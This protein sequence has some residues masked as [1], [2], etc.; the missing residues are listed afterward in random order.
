MGRWRNESPPRNFRGRALDPR[1]SILGRIGE[2]AGRTG[3]EL[4]PGGQRDRISDE[5]NRPVPPGDVDATRVVAAGGEVGFLE[6]II[7][8]RVRV[9]WVGLVRDT[10]VA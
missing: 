6:E 9:E 10:V 4:L 3:A 1:R 5:A 7:A 8:V 2:V